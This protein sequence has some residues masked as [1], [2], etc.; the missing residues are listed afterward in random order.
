[1]GGKFIAQENQEKK[2]IWNIFVTVAIVLV[3]VMLGLSVGGTMYNRAKRKKR[4]RIKRR[5]ERECI[6]KID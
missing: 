4:E 2:R 1:M 5:N 6:R 3:F